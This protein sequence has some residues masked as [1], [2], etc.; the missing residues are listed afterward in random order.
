MV[1]VGIALL[2]FISSAYAAEVPR[3]VFSLTPPNKPVNSAIL[4][5]PSVVGVSIRAQWQTVEQ[6]EGLY[7]WS[8]FDN[9]I[10][11]AMNAG[12]TV[13]LRIP[14]GGQNTP[15]WVFDAGIQT[16]SF[17][18]T[19]R[20]HDTYGQTLTIPVFWDPVFLAK[21]KSFIAAMGRHFATNSHIVLVSVACANSI[22]DDW[23]VPSSKTDVKNWLAIGYT[24][25][26][27]INACNELIDASMEAMPNKTIFLSINASSNH[28]DP[29]PDYVPRNVVERAMKMYPGRFIVQKN[30]LSAD[31]PDPALI[32]ALGNWQIIFDNQPEV[33]GQML[34]YVTNDSTCRMNS[35]V[36]PCDPA[37]VLQEAVRT[38][39][40]YGMSYLEIYQPDILN[41]AL[42]GVIS[43]AA[44]VLAP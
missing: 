1:S 35:G 36:K 17:M 31:T 43:Y 37:A 6:T 24:S 2:V 42:V 34:W 13:L 33:A 40:E 16:F 8:Y 3:G 32:S 9:Q 5:N 39:G 30:S 12:K 15:Q 18:D 19:I 23:N 28:L 10:T 29:A 27:L 20:Y 41:P 38:G 14:A 44:D 22:T 21:K 4:T 25:D 26:K 7:N 11:R